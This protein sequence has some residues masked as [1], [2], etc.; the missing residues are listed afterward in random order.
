MSSSQMKQL[1][2]PNLKEFH[3]ECEC[4]DVYK[5]IVTMNISKTKG[6]VKICFRYVHGDNTLSFRYMFMV[7][8]PQKSSIHLLVMLPKIFNKW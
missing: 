5:G 2:L 1:Q 6:I 3:G 8:I 7:T 4:I